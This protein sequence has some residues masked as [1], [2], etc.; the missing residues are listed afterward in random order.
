[1]RREVSRLRSDRPCNSPWWLSGKYPASAPSGRRTGLARPCRGHRPN[2]ATI[3]GCSQVTQPT[4]WG[5]PDSHGQSRVSRRRRW[6]ERLMAS[7]SACFAAVAG[8]TDVLAG[9]PICGDL[10][11]HLCRSRGRAVAERRRLLQRRMALACAAT[12]AT[13]VHRRPSASEG[14][15]IDGIE[16][17][18]LRHRRRRRRWPPPSLPVRS[19]T[20]VG[21]GHSPACSRLSASPPRRRACVRD[22]S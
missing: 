17:Q 3:S 13:R 12:V 2:S 16:A 4:T 19:V 14:P 22:Q 7:A 5:F 11:A 15:C 9:S 10:Q 21:A 8:A 18:A 1:M 20:M 6:P